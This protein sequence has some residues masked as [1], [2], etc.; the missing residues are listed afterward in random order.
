MEIAGVDSKLLMASSPSGIDTV[1]DVIGANIDWTRKMVYLY[2]IG[3][4]VCR[5]KNL[6]GDKT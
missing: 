1:G 2:V 5:H 3:N 6:N 4:D